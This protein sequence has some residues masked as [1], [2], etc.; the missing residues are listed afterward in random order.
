LPGPI[1]WYFTVQP[2]NPDFFLSVQ[3]QFFAGVPVNDIYTE[4][5]FNDW[6]AGATGAGG[7]PIPAISGNSLSKIRYPAYVVMYMDAIDWNPRHNGG[8]NICFVDAHV[9]RF[10]E[11]EYFDADGSDNYANAKDKDAFGNRPYWCWGLG[12]GIVGD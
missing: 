1:P 8:N 3:N 9:E 5:W 10:K 7:I 2:A 12:H 4:Y 11:V 6:N